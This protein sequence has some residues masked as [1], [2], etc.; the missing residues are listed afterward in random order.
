MSML[1]LSHSEVEQLLPMKECITVM[2]EAFTGLAHNQFH[3]PLRTI[4]K[5]PSVKGVMAMMPSFRGGDDPLFALKAICVFPGNAALGKDAH[6]GGVILFDGAT[7]EPRAMV[8][9]S[10]ITAIRTAAVSGLATRLLSREDAGDLAIFGAGVQARTHLTA[11]AC[12]RKLKRVRIVARR[13]ESAQKCAQ[14]MQAEESVPI[15]IKIARTHPNQM[16]RKQAIRSLG[17]SGDPRAVDFF[18]EVLTK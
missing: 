7:G 15:L 17:E 10:A 8:N 9:A 4:T 11:M 13:L 6:Q 1:I 2:E 16:V 14:E 3:Q 12:V 18:K 5:P